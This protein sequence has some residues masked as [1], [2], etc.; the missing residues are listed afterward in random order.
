M[1]LVFHMALP[2]ESVLTTILENKLGV[3]SVKGT[4]LLH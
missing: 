1:S 3:I 4:L 2:S